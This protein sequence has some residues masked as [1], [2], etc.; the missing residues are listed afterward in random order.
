MKH[1]VQQQMHGGRA[2]LSAMITKVSALALTTA[3]S[4]GSASV[5]AQEVNLRM[6]SSWPEN[7]AYTKNVAATFVQMMDEISD[8]EIAIRIDGPEVVGPLEQIEPVQAGVFDILFTHPAYHVGTATLGMGVEGTVADPALRRSSGVFDTLDEY[9]QGLGLKVVAIA[10]LGTSA[11]NFILKEPVSG[12]PSLDGLKVRGNQL[13]FPVIEGLG[14]A[15]V[16]LPMSDIYSSLQ[17]GVIDGAGTTVIGIREQNWHEVAG[18]LSRP[19][20]GS[21]SAYIFMNLDTWNGLSDDQQRLI[22]TAALALE[23]E[24]QT[25]FDAMAKEEEAFLLSNGMQVTEL[26]AEEAEK[27]NSLMFDGAWQVAMTAGDIAERMHQQAADAGLI[28]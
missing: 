22:E 27:L 13:Y 21:T 6:L 15:P 23:T 2:A 10:P 1:A 11:F 12:M 5:S 8:G 20:F 4:L 17:T 7:Q 24:V 9:Y 18:Y 14:G 16:N 26:P 28:D 19:V 3:I 25:V